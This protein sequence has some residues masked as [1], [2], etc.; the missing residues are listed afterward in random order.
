MADIQ[1]AAQLH[2]AET[3]GFASL[4]GSTGRPRIYP[5]KAPQGT[6]TP[7]VTYQTINDAE[8]YTF[9]SDPNYAQAR[10][11]FSIWSTSHISCRGIRDQLRLAMR[12]QR[13]VL[14]P[15]TGTIRVDGA[16]KA[17]EI[18]LAEDDNEDK[19]SF[20]IIY[21]FYIWHTLD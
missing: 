21:D 16:L 14:W 8:V 17:S 5:V 19:D 12:D 2:L 4:I 11:S 9:G 6:T 18:D 15:S 7:Y 10:L 1:K 13:G 20:C 3:T